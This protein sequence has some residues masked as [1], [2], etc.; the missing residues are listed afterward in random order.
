MWTASIINKFSF[1]STI[2]FIKGDIEESYTLENKIGEGSYGSV[3]K[4]I[5]DTDE[6]ALKIYSSTD[7]L[8]NIL[9]YEQLD[10]TVEKNKEYYLK[11]VA[12]HDLLNDMLTPY[13][14]RFFTLYIKHG[15]YTTN[16]FFILM[17]YY[18][19][20]KYFK[21]KDID[22]VLNIT[23]QVTD[24]LVTLQKYSLIHGD[25][26]VDNL[27]LDNLNNVVVC[28]LSSIRVINKTSTFI[29]ITQTPFI[30]TPECLVGSFCTET[31]IYDNIDIVGVSDVILCLLTD[32]TMSLHTDKKETRN[33]TPFTKTL[34][35][36]F[37]KNYYK[38]FY[39]LYS[40]S[41][42]KYTTDTINI[43]DD[44]RNHSLRG[45]FFISDNLEIKNMFSNDLYH[46]Y[47]SFVESLISSLCKTMKN[48]VNSVK[49]NT[50]ISYLFEVIEF[51]YQLRIKPKDA[52]IFYSNI[53]YKYVLEKKEDNNFKLYLFNDFL[54]SFTLNK[55]HFFYL[56]DSL[57]VL[58]IYSDKHEYTE[59]IIKNNS[60][61]E[62]YGKYGDKM[63]TIKKLNS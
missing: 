16:N 37:I 45:S 39:F 28:D 33:F 50:L 62:Y 63:F 48:E 11:E 60:Q 3:Y 57:F 49:F 35:K 15:Q 56:V 18:T 47:R 32:R 10:K 42:Y 24:R 30:S 27:L 23:S 36:D 9:Y 53:L 12:A 41:E 46:E 6:Y 29:D 59:E 7:V 2:K 31:R 19:Q 54:F 5:K 55:D 22:T 61:L 51:N 1:K 8:G 17:P 52:F 40:L 26:K 38:Q 4:L 58:E 14:K 20:L 21:V 43:L 34:R 44:F 13:E 25:F